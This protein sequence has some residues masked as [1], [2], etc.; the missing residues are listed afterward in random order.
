MLSV[1]VGLPSLQGQF[2]ADDFTWLNLLSTKPLEIILDGFHGR[3]M[4]Y[5]IFG[6]HY[7]PLLS[8]PFLIDAQLFGTNA[9]LLHLSNLLWN[10][11]CT[12]IVFFVCR[13][14][15][16]A[17]SAPHSVRIAFWA[18]AVFA[19]HPFHCE[20]IGWWTA[21]NDIVFSLFFLLSLNF[22]LSPKKQDRIYSYITFVIALCCKETAL[23]L[24]ALICVFEILKQIFQEQK[25]WTQYSFKSLS[26]ILFKSITQT[27]FYFLVLGGFWLLRTLCLGQLG[28][29]YYGS[30]TS[31]WLENL[32]D[33]FGNLT[34]DSIL[35]YPVDFNDGT[36]SDT[37]LAL[38]AAVYLTFSVAA[39]IGLFQRQA[40]NI[41][42]QDA[43]YAHTDW[44][45]GSFASLLL[46]VATFASLALIPTCL[47]WSPNTSLAGTRLL[48]LFSVP[49]SI[50]YSI[51]L[52]GPLL[53]SKNKEARNK[54]NYLQIGL[55]LSIIALLTISTIQAH[56]RW[57]F[58][59]T[60]LT[61]LAQRME[62]EAAKLPGEQRL[63]LLDIP[64]AIRGI[65][66]I[67]HFSILQDCLRPPFQSGDNAGKLAAFEPHFFAEHDLINVQRLHAI[68]R[69]VE[70]ARLYYV[71]PSDKLSTGNIFDLSNAKQ[72]KLQELNA[73]E[74]VNTGSA[75]K[76]RSFP[77]STG[78]SRVSKGLVLRYFPLTLDAPING[79][80][81]GILRLHLGNAATAEKLKFTIYW[82]SAKSKIFDKEHSKFFHEPCEL[83]AK[84]EIK[85]T[86]NYDSTKRC[87]TVNL[88][89]SIS[90]MKEH[91]IDSVLIMAMGSGPAIES[92]EFFNSG[93]LLPS[94]QSSHLDNN[95]FSQSGVL[96][97]IKHRYEFS[98]DASSIPECT[99]VLVEV[100]PALVDFMDINEKQLD[101][102]V[103][104][105]A[106]RTIFVE[107]NKSTI[108]MDDKL[109]SPVWHQ[110][111]VRPLDKSH[112]PVGYASGPLYL[113]S[114]SEKSLP[115]SIDAGG[116][117]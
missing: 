69:G 34:K 30:L 27:K 59:S 86:Q 88:G 54:N 6:E 17:F 98:Y 107:D 38:F 114:V 35:W 50:L 29:S 33:R 78:E 70:Q 12:L 95:S 14:I 26:S 60:F 61:A 85:Q 49:L 21:K 87:I 11:A 65:S 48:Y 20:N 80:D 23:I 106:V 94:I 40:R 41:S 44:K 45:P 1:L 82:K 37:M 63:F 99:G 96:K 47:I 111:R 62:S 7:R 102:K 97:S 103:C 31:L 10:S 76:T 84:E 2:L 4:Y 73:R 91:D 75:P 90:W 43:V 3:Y 24:P 81:F 52:N 71:S 89:S 116:R 117:K 8:I 67:H 101:S 104:S 72:F 113:Q 115:E 92:A 46:F 13:S 22:F 77:A 79:A 74:L 68:A 100:T 83:I 32:D 51:L 25:S 109:G 64:R 28:G 19:V 39:L 55:Q 18:A 42:Q 58:A 66:I 5:P 16:M 57:S 105:K 110:V 53:E 112:N 15:C 36:F 108:S 9:A 56:Q 93:E